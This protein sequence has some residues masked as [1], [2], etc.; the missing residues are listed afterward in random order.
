[1]D[2]DFHRYD[3]QKVL[4][5]MKKIIIALI[6][7]I[8]IVSF[9]HGQT[10]IIR[11]NATAGY[12]YADDIKGMA[13]SYGSTLLLSANEIQRYGL[14]IDHLIMPNNNELSYLCAGII[15]E[16]VLFNYFNMGIGTIG[17][18][19]LVQIGENP[20]GLYTHLGFEYNFSERFN[21][22]ASYRSDFIFR[23]HFAMYNAFQLG[24][25]IKF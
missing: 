25:G 12:F 9:S 22:A 19:N 7:C 4:G 18:I 2:T 23:R 8:I 3:R 21:I 24:F 15:I 20:F 17:Y 10:L 13:V 16:Q 11:P 14:I 5:L 1:M 6:F